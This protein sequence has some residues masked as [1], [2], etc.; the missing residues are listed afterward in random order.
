MRG[1][2]VTEI[3][4]ME[5]D[6]DL[7][8]IKYSLTFCQPIFPPLSIFFPFLKKKGSIEFIFIPLQKGGKKGVRGKNYFM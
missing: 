8:K 4:D 2:T 6:H 7:V 5:K 1:P 3:N